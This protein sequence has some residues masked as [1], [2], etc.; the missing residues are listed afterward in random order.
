MPNPTI[1]GI[2][3]SIISGFPRALK[4]EVQTWRT[5]GLD[6]YGAQQKGKGSAEFDL[7]TLT[8]VAS[9]GMFTADQILASYIALCGT[10]VSVVDNWGITYANI[11]I[12]DI[13]DANAKK[14]I[15]WNG[16]AGAVLIQ[17]K[18][19]CVTSATSP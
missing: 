19:S 7:A 1:G 5:P 9:G 13:D 8:F 10:V 14:K 4:M 16:D 3:C 2:D 18:W 15:I 12:K 11:L 6:G 17:L